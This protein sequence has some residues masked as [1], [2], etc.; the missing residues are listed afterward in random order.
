MFG[1]LPWRR[2]KARPAPLAL[3]EGEPFR[4]LREMGSLFDRLFGIWPEPFVVE[5]VVR[6]FEVEEKDGQIVV[7]TEA[8]GF[9]LADFDIRVS[10]NLLTV[11]AEHREK[12]GKERAE[13][14]GIYMD[15][16]MTLPPCIE[17]EK[18]TAVYRNGVLEMHL[19]RKPEA[20]G[21]RIEVT[22]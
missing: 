20:L 21:R 10:D 8:P 9:E 12:N 17:P 3:R 6:P 14:R 13:A 7:R 1:L 19:P 5:P 16:A 15:E 11:R 18:V 4:L 22:T 2:E